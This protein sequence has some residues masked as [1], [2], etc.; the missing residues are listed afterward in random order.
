[1]DDFLLGCKQYTYYMLNY[2]PLSVVYIKL[3]TYYIF[4]HLHLA[5]GSEWPHWPYMVTEIGRDLVYETTLFLL[6]KTMDIG[7]V[8]V[9]WVSIFMVFL[10]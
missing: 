3:Y 10:H 9:A 4:T 1:M 8:C 5:M 2:T 6:R 7:L